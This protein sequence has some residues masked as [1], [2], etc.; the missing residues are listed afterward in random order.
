[1]GLH[2][3][4]LRILV[5]TFLSSSVISKSLNFLEENSAKA[6]LSRT[7]RYVTFTGET[8][9]CFTE[10]QLC[11]FESFAERA[12]NQFGKQVFGAKIGF[13]RRREPDT[14]TFEFFGENYMKCGSSELA[15]GCKQRIHQYL[16][17]AG[18]SGANKVEC[19]ETHSK[20]SVQD[21]TNVQPKVG[22]GGRNGQKKN[23]LP[24]S[25]SNKKSWMLDLA[26]PTDSPFKLNDYE[27]E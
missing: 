4:M 10:D 14:T 11:T 21:K 20:K 7:K 18:T 1:M 3:N 15:H 2:I 27:Y 6:F 23:Q 5:I 17:C 24:E 8:E 16:H 9:E 12:E 26:N 22:N 25:K 19:K 13:L